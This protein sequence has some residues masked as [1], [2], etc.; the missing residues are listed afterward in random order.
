MVICGAGI[1][2]LAL[3]GCLD[4]LG[5]EVVVLERAPGPR[6]Q[7]YMIDFFGPGY[8]A[9][10]AIGLLP[11]LRQL[12]YPV[13]E[14]CYVDESGRRKAGLD[15]ARFTR[16]AGGQ[17]LSLMRP[18]LEMALRERLPG[19][20]DVRFATSVTGIDNR[21]GGVRVTLTDASVLEAD[22]LVGADGIHSAVRRLAFGDEG[23]F[24]RYLGCHTAAF[25]FYD[26]HLHAELGDRFCL[27]DTVDRQMGFYGL[28]DGRVAVFAV[29]RSNDPALPEDAR[30]ALRQEY[31]GLGW[32]V[33]EALDQCPSADGV[34]YDQVAQVE[35]GQW[36]RGRVTL[37]GDAGYA[38]SLLAGQG[39][40][41]GVAGAYVL[42]RQLSATALVE[43]AL[44]RYERCWRPMVAPRQQAAHHSAKWFLPDSRRRLQARRISLRL[45]R[46]PLLDRY[47]V[48]S[49][50]GKGAMTLDDEPPAAPDRP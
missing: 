21:A 15:Y 17:V 19:R 40:S 11:R 8:T 49:L 4:H 7:G 36:S 38:V 13:H 34:Y 50:I 43:T 2:G 25:T 14:L 23:R 33:P 47:F 24:V 1:A 39:A 5:W 46:L 31:S 26:P 6:T 42:A 28:R 37:I 3:A 45:A 35:V 12:R 9:A 44:E 16:A 48:T 20:V 32:I 22:L 30:A 18:D 10:A 41:L 29:H 27:T